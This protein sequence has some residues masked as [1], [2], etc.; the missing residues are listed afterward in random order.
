[1][2][3]CVRGWRGRYTAV[4]VGRTQQCALYMALQR[5]VVLLM[6]PRKLLGMVPIVARP[7]T[8]LLL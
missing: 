8:L 2:C 3:E 5:S 1:V 4:C 7:H 6:L